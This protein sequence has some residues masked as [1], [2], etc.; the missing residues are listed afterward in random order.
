M[1]AYFNLTE[2]RRV[3]AG[4]IRGSLV[5][6]INNGLIANNPERQRRERSERRAR[7]VARS[8]AKN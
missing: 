4:A 1:M 5:A 6:V 7:A 3:V 8:S 2:P